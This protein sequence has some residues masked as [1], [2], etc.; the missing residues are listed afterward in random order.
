MDNN[1]ELLINNVFDN[2]SS[3]V[4]TENLDNFPNLEQLS[5]MQLQALRSKVND[6]D[7]R[8]KYIDRIKM[9]CYKKDFEYYKNVYFKPNHDNEQI[10]VQ[11]SAELIDNQMFCIKLIDN[12]NSVWLNSNKELS[13][14]EVALQNALKTSKEKVVLERKSMVMMD[15]L[16][17]DPQ[18]QDNILLTMY[19]ARFIK[20]DEMKAWSN[21]E[22]HKNDKEDN[23]PGISIPFVVIL[24]IATVFVVWL[25]NKQ[26]KSNDDEN[27]K[28]KDLEIRE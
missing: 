25:K 3:V 14:G 6:N 2:T 1:N 19:A 4:K 15:Q 13:K 22:L 9:D 12:Y 10:M 20:V 21:Y 17:K 11:K 24:L 7:F 28:N 8:L 26:T 16:K 27:K 23:D 5:S 18:I